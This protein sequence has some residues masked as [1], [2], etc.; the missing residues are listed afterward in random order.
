M[1]TESWA[2]WENVLD[3]RTGDQQNLTLACYASQAMRKPWWVVVL[4]GVL[5]LRAAMR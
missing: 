4:S 1:N 3:L 5:A 2:T